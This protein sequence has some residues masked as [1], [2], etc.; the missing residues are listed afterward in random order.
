MRAPAVTYKLG[1]D[2]ANVCP[3]GTV[4]IP[5]VPT[6]KAAAASIGIAYF[7]GTNDA[8]WPTGCLL[9]YFSAKGDVYYNFH[10]TGAGL[11]SY[12]P[13]CMAGAALAPPKRPGWPGERRRRMFV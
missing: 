8:K 9:S 5:D 7:Q 2:G 3:S 4:K 11:S 6:C 10:A 1:A 12:Q 13:L